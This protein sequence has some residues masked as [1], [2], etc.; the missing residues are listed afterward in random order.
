MSSFLSPDR[1]KRQSAAAAAK[2]AMLERFRA[3][4]EDPRI[5]EKQAERATIVAAREKRMAERETAKRAREAELAVEAARL[6]EAERLAR[7]EDEKLQALV[8]AE[9]A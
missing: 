4:S 9:Q 5:A 2:K 3:A 7:V 1:E 6:A 8:V